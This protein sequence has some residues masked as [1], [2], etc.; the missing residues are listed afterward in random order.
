MQSIHSSHT[1]IDLPEQLVSCLPIS[2]CNAVEK[3]G[4]QSI[5]EIRLHRGRVATVTYGG[6]NYYTNFILKERDINDILHRMCAGSL[7]AFEESINNGYLTLD[8][9]I[10]VGIC[11]SAA[12]DADKV[13]GISNITGLIIRIPHRHR[14]SVKP[15]LEEL[16]RGQGLRGVLLYAPPGIGKTTVLRTIAIEASSPLYGIRTVV[17]DT[18]EELGYTLD[19][20]RLTLDILSGYPR[21]IGIEIATRSLGAQ[22]I[23]C[24]EIGGGRDAHAILSAANCG[25]PLIASAHAG[26]LS[27]LLQRPS[28]QLL[29]RYGVFGCYVGLQRD[30]MGGFV[31]HITAHAEAQKT[32]ERT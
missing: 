16:E 11:G 10:R 18:R 21:Q 8:G 15:I 2:L 14:V 25:V 17:V 27:E 1:P 31:Y 6:K 29:H 12:L 23:I 9:G 19:G 24:D 7:Y 30:H 28:I 5:E 4:A 22:L 32:L 26:S 13:I 20:E 3:S